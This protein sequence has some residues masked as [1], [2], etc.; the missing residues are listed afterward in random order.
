MDTLN[1]EQRHKAMAAVKS[2]NTTPELVVRKLLHKEGF[3]FRLHRKD[4]PGK[5][6]ILLPKYHTIILVHGCFWHQHHGCKRSTRPTSNDD[7]WRVKLERNVARDQKNISELEAINWKVLVIWECET[8]DKSVLS[9]KISSFLS[10]T[11]FYKKP[12][13]QGRV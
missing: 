2:K 8:K 3:R 4:L 7:Y 11:S 12:D 9:K 13:H 1:P 10:N 5:P 6:D